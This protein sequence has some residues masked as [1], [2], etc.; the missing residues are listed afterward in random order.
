MLEF[1]IER[2]IGHVALQDFPYV[3]RDI[4]PPLREVDT[5]VAPASRRRSRGA[6]PP[7]AKP[8]NAAAGIP[9]RQCKSRSCLNA[10]P[11]LLRFHSGQFSLNFC[12]QFP[13]A[14]DLCLL[15]L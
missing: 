15:P 13:Q 5:T 3:A 7:H 1:L 8:C 2:V 10:L 14:L 6:P 4:L 11:L 12:Q 9:V